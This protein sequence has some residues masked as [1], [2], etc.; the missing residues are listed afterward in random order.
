MEGRRDWAGGLGRSGALR[1]W[2]VRHGAIVIV[3]AAGLAVRAALVP[4]GHGQDFVVWQLAS[5]STLHGVN[6]YAHHPAY[7]GGPYAYFPLFLGLEL[8][9]RW[10][11][12]HTA[13]SFAVLGKLPIVASDVAVAVLLY[14]ML[15][16][17]HDRPARA[18]LGA[19]VF[20]LNPL[21]LYN[22]AY[23]GRFD[24]LACAL[25]LAFTMNSENGAVRRTRAYVYYALAIA[26]KTFP[27]F[28]APTALRA[29]GSRWRVL[30][31]VTVAVLV[32]L[33]VPYLAAPWPYVRDIVGYDT[34]K[35]PAGLSWW[36]V[37]NGFCSPTVAGIVSG[38]GLLA[39]VLGTVIIARR[40][41]ADLDVA[42]VATL[43]LFLI[44]SK[45]VLEQYL[46][47]PMPWLITI[48][49]RQRSRLAVASAVVLVVFTVAGL[50]D[51]ETFHPIGRDSPVIGF[52]LAVVCGV[53]LRICFRG[54][55]RPSGP[56]GLESGMATATVDV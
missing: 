56:A 5:T 8:P 22:G 18:A 6:V 11:S 13:A 28:V 32:G 35:I 26:A 27:V 17:R 41:G 55:E 7:P 48:A 37:L 25:L 30:V 40:V 39:F 44:C 16:R 45:L 14:R 38:I 4:L 47:W 33:S 51:N 34:G 15:L 24:V 20:L 2:I 12:E 1:Q 43:L 19:A 50:L 21:V 52:V 29:A 9:L 42:I 54:A 3:C 31:A 23:Y 49:M 36:T 10:L 46:I 53:Y